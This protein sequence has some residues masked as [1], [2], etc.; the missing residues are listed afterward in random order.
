MDTIIIKKDGILEIRSWDVEQNGYEYYRVSST[1]VLK[2]LQYSAI[3][4]NGFTLRDYFKIIENYPQLKELDGFFESYLKEY[5]KCPDS[6][7]KDEKFDYLVLDRI[8]DL[9]MESIMDSYISFG[10]IGTHEG[11]KVNYAVELTPLNDILDLEIKIGTGKVYCPDQK[12]IINKPDISFKLWDIIH[13]IIWE[14]SFCGDPDRR[15]KECELLLGLYNQVINKDPE[16]ELKD[17]KE[18]GKQE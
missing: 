1:D 6:N 13:E 9:Q 14:L 3:I 4:E 11:E 7:C 10:A 17:F 16:V 15:S 8:V 18:F 2:F 5:Y 12:V